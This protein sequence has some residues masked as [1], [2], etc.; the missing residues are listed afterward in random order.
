MS[1]YRKASLAAELT[2]ARAA[3]RAAGIETE[4]PRTIDEVDARAREVFAYVLREGITNVVRH[5]GAT[6]CQVMFG[7]CSLEIVDNGHGA[8]GAGDGHGLHGLRERMSA[9]DGELMTES[10]PGKGFRLKASIR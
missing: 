1:D 3:L 8:D 6:R 5:S 4:L 9:I 10:A 2:N 7:P